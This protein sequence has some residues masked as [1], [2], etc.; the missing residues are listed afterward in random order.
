MCDRRFRSL[1]FLLLSWSVATSIIVTPAYAQKSGGASGQG[2]GAGQAG[3]QGGGS[4]PFFETE[5]LAY[6]AAN[7]LSEAVA[8]KVCENIPEGKSTVIIFDQVSFQNL[9]AWQSF[10]AS[11]NFL[12]A[13]YDS[14][15]GKASNAESHAPNA[16]PTSSTS[17]IPGATDLASLLGAVAAGTTQNSSAF[18]IQDSSLAVSLAHQLS[19]ICKK[20][21]VPVYYPLFGGFVDPKVA[22]ADV[23]AAM[24]KVN[25]A[26][27]DI[28]PSTTG[29]PEKIFEDLNTQYDLLLKVLLPSSSMAASG[30]GNSQGMS[31][32]GSGQSSSTPTAGFTSVLQGAALQRL[33][34]RPQTYILYADVVAAGG[35]QQ[36]RKNLLTL[37]F[38]GDR[39]SYSGGLVVNVAL[40]DALDSS[41]VFSDTLRYR[42]RFSRIGRPKESPTVERTNSGDNVE[43][44]YNAE[45]LRFFWQERQSPNDCEAA[46]AARVAIS[47]VK[48]DLSEVASG[49]TSQVNGVV[50]LT[51]ACHEDVR[52]EL[53][54][55]VPT[56]A[57]VESTVLVKSGQKTAGFTV[58]LKEGI[59]LPPFP[60]VEAH[61]PP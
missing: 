26:R 14:L 15:K 4:N 38:T 9:Q 11:A 30:S 52:V 54:S 25:E 53:S 1:V 41:L 51:S 40:T 44:L 35:T 29:W 57:Q 12:A 2:Q 46:P 24:F 21:L 45:G 37:L 59:C 10:E 13:A 48:T 31:P 16:A 55:S 43:S 23:M 17:F 18:T 8:R 61:P 27:R 49:S 33:I 50:T 6:G 60:G 36:V 28:T 39:I 22:R 32:Q 5:M 42:T 47:K 19:K 20:R 58:T 34:S 56:A 3:G 7:E